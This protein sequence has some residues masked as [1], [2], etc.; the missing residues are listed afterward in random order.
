MT[1]KEN[2]LERPFIGFLGPLFHMKNFNA[3]S[4][5]KGCPTVTTV[6]QSLLMNIHHLT[7]VVRVP[8]I[9]KE[10][11]V[12]CLTKSLLTHILRT[13]GGSRQPIMMGSQNF[14]RFIFWGFAPLHFSQSSIMKR[15]NRKIAAPFQTLDMERKP[16][17]PDF[18]WN[19]KK[20][21]TTWPKHLETSSHNP[22]SWKDP[23]NYFSRFLCKGSMDPH[24]C[25]K[26]HQTLALWLKRFTSLSKCSPVPVSGLIL[27]G[28]L[29]KSQTL[30]LGLWNWKLPIETVSFLDLSNSSWDHGKLWKITS[31]PA[32]SIVFLQSS[33]LRN[34]KS[35]KWWY[36]AVV[37]W[38]RHD[39]IF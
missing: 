33:L 6:T 25:T 15:Q 24:L 3:T 1:T 32:P 19:P 39:R 13:C 20:V 9:C 4:L 38:K 5:G 2:E 36:S 34:M 29:V 35:S 7:M 8:V 27:P 12:H 30:E 28:A 16:D 10:M 21:Y 17:N 18:W 11:V 23:C 22:S 37:I 31:P 14:S 26:H